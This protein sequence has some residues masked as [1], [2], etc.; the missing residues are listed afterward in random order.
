MYANSNNSWAIYA[1]FLLPTSIRPAFRYFPGTHLSGLPGTLPACE[2][3]TA[4]NTCYDPRERPWYELAVDV[5]TGISEETGLG[6][7]TITTPYIDVD[8]EANWMV[9]IARAVYDKTASTSNQLLG[10]VGVDV[11]LEAVQELVEEIHFLQSG[12]SILATAEEG[13]I[14]AAPATVWDRVEAV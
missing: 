1:G 11:L 3:G 6:D 7:V 12:Y 5:A 2:G 14:L 9:T 8:T 13:L 4:G 10:V